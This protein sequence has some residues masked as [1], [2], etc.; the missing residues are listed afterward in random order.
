VRLSEP[1]RTAF[2]ELV[3]S[4]LK[5]AETLASK[6]PAETALTPAVSMFEMRARLSAVRQATTAIRPAFTQF[7]ETLDQR[8][9]GP[10]CCDALMRIAFD[11]IQRTSR[12]FRIRSDGE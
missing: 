7:Y 6:C 11:E 8:P 3:T 12:S 2:Y 4:S 5:T 1:Q 10:I 9:E